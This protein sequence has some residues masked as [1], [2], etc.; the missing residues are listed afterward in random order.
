MWKL[1]SVN[2]L[3]LLFFDYVRLCCL[4]MASLASDNGTTKDVDVSAVFG[5]YPGCGC[6]HWVVP[7]R[8]L[9][10]ILRGFLVLLIYCSYY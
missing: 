8:K 5:L 7:G 9:I 3:Y 10:F 1:P 2:D 4:L 6:R